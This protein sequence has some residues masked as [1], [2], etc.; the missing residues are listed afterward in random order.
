MGYSI[1]VVAAAIVAQAAPA[2][3]AQEKGAAA[4]S[5][6]TELKEARRLLQNG[7]YAEAEEAFSAILADAKKKAEPLAPALKVAVIL[8]LADCQAS[9]GEYDKA[10]ERLKAAEAEDP[11]DADLPGAARRAVLDARRLGVR[12]GRDATGSEDRS[13]PPARPLGR[14]P[15]AG[16]S[17]RTREGRRRLQVV[18]RSL[19]RTTGARS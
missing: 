17:R 11:K 8:G 18:R 19:Q 12:R 1:V 15:A 5:V 4:G 3:K 2:P 13:R 10:I 7:R 6:Q 14:G 16:A 9:Q